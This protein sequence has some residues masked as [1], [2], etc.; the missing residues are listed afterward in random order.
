MA[1]YVGMVTVHLN[2]VYIALASQVGYHQ[3]K[4][5]FGGS[6]LVSPYG[7]MLVEPAGDQIPEVLQF[8]MDFSLGR[9]R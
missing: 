3:G 2:Q 9:G 1:N 6:C 8:E 4:W 7:W 5:L